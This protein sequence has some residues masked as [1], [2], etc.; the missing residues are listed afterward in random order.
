MNNRLWWVRRAGQ[1]AW[2]GL[3]ALLF[4]H[5]SY[6]LLLWDLVFRPSRWAKR[7]ERV[8]PALPG[9]FVLPQLLPE[10]FR[11][12][13]FRNLLLYSFTAPL[14]VSALFMGLEG[15][16]L[17][18]SQKATYPAALGLAFLVMIFLTILSGSTISAAAGIGSML[19]TACAAPIL[20]GS[21][22]FSEG[23]FSFGYQLVLFACFSWGTVLYF[24]GK[25]APLHP[26]AR[27]WR[28][29]RLGLVQ[30]AKGFLLAGAI[31]FLSAVPV[32]ILTEKAT[33]MT[34]ALPSG[35][36]VAFDWILFYF[37]VYSTSASIWAKPARWRIK[38][39]AILAV[40]AVL[41]GFALLAMYT[42][43]QIPPAGGFEPP[44]PTWKNTALLF[45]LVSAITLLSYVVYPYRS[46][47]N[48]FVCIL[49][50][51]IFLSGSTTAALAALFFGSFLLALLR[52]MLLY[53]LLTLWNLLLYLWDR[54]PWTHPKQFG[55]H[56]AFWDEQQPLPWIG[57]DAHAALALKQG[58]PQI[59]ERETYLQD[60][61]QEW[62]FQAPSAGRM[63]SF[64][65][66]RARG[67]GRMVWLV[68]TFL[69]LGLLLGAFWKGLQRPDRATSEPQES[70][71]LVTTLKPILAGEQIQADQVQTT[72]V[73]GP[74]ESL[75]MVP[76]LSSPVIAGRTAR[77]DI[78][79]GVTL[80]ENML[81]P[82]SEV[83]P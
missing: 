56:A 65:E 34:S 36:S 61:G 59:E 68:A 16:F 72:V 52:P 30:T 21:I 27:G 8:H 83:R 37:F 17:P 29:I 45:L 54:L 49:A 79:A 23:W 2:K 43:E 53:P 38:L 20:L 19:L 39:A 44:S 4:L 62:A 63:R 31:F 40:L 26:G 57:L 42:P 15:L 77:V 50:L 69:I 47:R 75:W 71:V 24:G 14:V 81:V 48:T 11:Q 46:W 5:G 18:D 10:H 58:A 51:Q 22:F 35:S 70:R 73:Q 13:E 6:L 76:R 74:E 60:T 80:N 55:R 1:G 7:L 3:Q 41:G 32:V 82:S 33:T 67:W 25:F 28:G 9:D 64:V 78:P 12:R 66:I